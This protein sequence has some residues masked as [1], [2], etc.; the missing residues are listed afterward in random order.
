MRILSL[1]PLAGPGVERLR[2][3][4]DLEIDPWS[5]HVPVKLHSADELRARLDGV[6]V[7]IVE[8]DH[9]GADVID[10]SSLRFIGVCRGDPVN[11]DIAAASK[12][13]ITVVRTPGRN[14]SAVSELAIGLMYAVLRSIVAADADIRA[15]RWVV[16][17]K[18]AQQR[19]MGRELSSLDVGLV[20]FG[21][22]AREVANKARSLAKS[23]NAYDPFVS[24]E[25]MRSGGVLAMTA[26]GDVIAAS[27][28]ISVHV[29]KNPSTVG[30][31]G[32]P[33]LS[34]AR[35]GAIL[36]NTARYEVVDEDALLGALRTGRLAG[37]G[38]DHF[39]NEFLPADH[40]LVGM[41]NV[42][43]TPHIGG[44]TIE[45]IEHHT[46][47]IADGLAAALSGKTPATAVT[48]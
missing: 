16:D 32:A 23:V 20:G 40:P 43:L 14:A 45:T 4:G 35:P 17:G 44:S 24:A 33:E 6:D 5:A 19:Y 1:A 15:A 13:G 36:I 25:E 41:P 30:M 10:G 21:A 18:I 46:T 3:L 48:S 37:A 47:T 12:Q 27:D 9:V 29:P 28:V 34:C 7:L 22:V 2:A 42:V 11:V 31:I 39:H 8:A 38:L 26:L